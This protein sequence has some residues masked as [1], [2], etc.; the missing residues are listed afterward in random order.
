MTHPLIIWDYLLEVKQ[1]SA[2]PLVTV[3]I[4]Y[5]QTRIIKLNK[6]SC[7]DIWVRSAKPSD[8]DSGCVWECVCVSVCVGM[9][10]RVCVRVCVGVCELKGDD[11]RMKDVMRWKQMLRTGASADGHS[12][13]Q[14]THTHVHSSPPSHTHTRLPLY[15]ATGSTFFSGLSMSDDVLLLV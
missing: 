4:C 14:V 5:T 2:L 7:C 15:F 6:I 11:N 13:S 1:F 9:C 8:M 10:V 12:K 3:F